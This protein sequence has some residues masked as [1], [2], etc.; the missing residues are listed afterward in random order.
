MLLRENMNRCF[1]GFSA[2]GSLLPDN[3]AV[4]CEG[5]GGG[6]AQVGGGIVNTGATECQRGGGG[7]RETDPVHKNFKGSL[8]T[9]SLEESFRKFLVPVDLELRS[10]LTLWSPGGSQRFSPLSDDT[11]AE[12]WRSGVCEV[13]EHHQTPAGVYLRPKPETKLILYTSEECRTQRATPC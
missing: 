4:S 1:V 10:S 6:P 13:K 2:L 3:G 5:R 7:Y 12:T 11:E 8:Q 9:G